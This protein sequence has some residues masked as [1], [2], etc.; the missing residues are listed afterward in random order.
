MTTAAGLALLALAASP[1]HV[2]A[3]PGASVALTVRNTGSAT[4]VVTAAAAGFRLDLRGRPV[5]GGVARAW[6]RAA[7][8]RLALRPGA[9]GVVHVH[10]VA[11]KGASPG[12]HARVL[13]LTATAVGANGIRLAARVGVLL[14]VRCPGRLVHRLDPVRLRR[15]GT[16]LRLLVVNRGN[17]DEWVTGDR[18]ALTLRRDGRAVAV[19]RARSQRV[20]ARSRAVFE[21]KLPARL[22][23]EVRVAAF[24]SG[25]VHRYRLRL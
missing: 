5:L 3:P 19:L 18:L 16:R 13:L 4:A 10:T 2:V 24:L 8:Q 17:L 20:L 9:Q 6:L 12:D 23:G 14:V 1:L 21:W 15:V 7:P 22:V 11:P 25:R